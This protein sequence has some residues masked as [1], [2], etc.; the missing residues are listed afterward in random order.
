MAVSASQLK[1]RLAELLEIS[2]KDADDILWALSQVAEETVKNADT[3]TLP[4]IGRLK[5]AVAEAR[6]GRNPATGESIKIPAKVRVSFSV[7]TPLKEMAPDVR[8]GR[9]IL[10]ERE[11]EKV[12][13][14]E[15]RERTAKRN[16]R[17]KVSA[18]LSRR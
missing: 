11:E 15:E 1:K 8:K 2:T 13:A 4:G 17:K 12:E 10:A 18:K 16:D 3:L 5:C 6:M 7:A 14:R 9:K